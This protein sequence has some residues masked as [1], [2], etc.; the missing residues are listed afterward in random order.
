MS[1]PTPKPRRYAAPSRA[2]MTRLDR[3]AWAAVERAM[4]ELNLSQSGA[5]HHL[6]RLGAGLPPLL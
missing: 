1:D 4:A 6:V 5:I 2:C 3:D